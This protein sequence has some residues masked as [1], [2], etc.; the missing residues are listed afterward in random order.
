MGGMDSTRTAGERS[1][2]ADPLRCFPLEPFRTL[3]QFLDAVLRGISSTTTRLG[4]PC[5]RASQ[6][7]RVPATLPSYSARRA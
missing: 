7:R 3:A 6:P 5:C 4:E 2:G 1:S